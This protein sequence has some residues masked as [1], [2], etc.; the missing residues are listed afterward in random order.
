MPTCQKSLNIK[1]AHLGLLLAP[2]IARVVVMEKKK[3]KKKPKDFDGCV[4]SRRPRRGG[5]WGGIKEVQPRLRRTCFI[6]R[7]LFAGVTANQLIK[8]RRC[9]CSCDGFFFYQPG[10]SHEKV[11]RKKK[12]KEGGT[13]GGFICARFLFLIGPSTAPAFASFKVTKELFIIW[14]KI[15]A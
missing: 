3:Q 10:R 9:R 6:I 15:T 13:N 4:R 5:W 11:G 1:G 8:P 12:K 7:L 14:W 2:L